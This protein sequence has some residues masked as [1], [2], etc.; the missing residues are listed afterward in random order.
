MM[1]VARFLTHRTPAFFSRLFAQ[2]FASLR[3]LLA[4]ARILRL[5]SLPGLTQVLHE[6]LELWVT[7]QRLEQRITLEPGI[8]REAGVHGITE[9]TEGLLVLAELGIGCA[10]TVSH[11]VVH[12]DS[13]DYGLQQFF[14][15]DS[16]AAC[17]EKT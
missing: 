5:R 6:T 7:T 14:C 15:L 11:M 2:A 12:V 17:C 4:S 10:K 8:A 9:P 3:S 16:L 13:P 1:A